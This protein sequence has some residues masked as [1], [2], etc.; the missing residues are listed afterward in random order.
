MF[1]VPTLLVQ[2]EEVETYMNNFL[3]EGYE[4]AVLRE[5]TSPYVFSV[6][7]KRSTTTLKYKKRDDLEVNVVSYT[8]GQARDQDAIVFVCEYNGHRFNVVQN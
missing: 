1:A 4:G 5:T 2:E 8:C 6:N 7:S 3:Q